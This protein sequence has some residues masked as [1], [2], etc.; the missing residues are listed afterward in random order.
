MTSLDASIGTPIAQRPSNQ[1]E[2]AMAT[3]FEV[4]H[5][6]DDTFSFQ[7]RNADGEVVVRSLGSS[8]KIMTQ[9]E[10]LHLRSAIRSS[11]E[12]IWHTAPDGSHFFVV[13]DKDGSVLAKSMKKRS[14]DELDTIQHQLVEAESAPMID[15]CK[16]SRSHAN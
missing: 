9:N 13:K 1:A 16:R 8:S 4:I 12:L 5:T 10:L 3:R 6:D 2:A 14:R 7:L 11:T 15:L